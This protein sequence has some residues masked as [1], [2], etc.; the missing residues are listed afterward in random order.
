MSLAI[1]SQA[2]EPRRFVNV[3]A[4]R[5]PQGRK[6]AVVFAYRLHGTHYTLSVNFTCHLK[7]IMQPGLNFVVTGPVAD[8]QTDS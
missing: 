2:V 3:E 1:R 8:Q 4:A 7:E 6:I 5:L